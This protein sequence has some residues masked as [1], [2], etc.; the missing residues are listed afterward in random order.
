VS[1]EQPI[2]HQHRVLS[3]NEECSCIFSVCC[4]VTRWKDYA[5]IR[6]AF[7]LQGFDTSNSEFLVCDNSSG[8][9]F[10]AYE[11][12]RKFMKEARGRYTLIVH[13][14]AYPLE[15]SSKLIRQL[16]ELEKVDP[17]WGVVG[18]AGVNRR[19][20]LRLVGALQMPGGAEISLDTP[21]AKVDAVD[22][23]VL[24]VRNG[25]GV[26]VSSDLRGFHLYGLD[27]CSVAARLGMSSYVIDYRWYH[28]S[29]GTI[30][31]DFFIT[32][33]ALQRKLK[34]YF[35]ITDSPTTCSYLSWS[36][37][38]CRGALADARSFCQVALG[39][40]HKEAR[41]CTLKEGLRNPLFLPALLGLI[42]FY[43]PR[44]IFRRIRRAFKARQ[45]SKHNS[46]A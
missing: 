10:D 29:Y 6:S 20:W 12:I 31:N 15:H 34:A 25:S 8:N 17:L 32:R 38:P 9:N 13:Q 40:R 28:G 19:M 22:E 33:S 43:G 27:I 36:R 1:R 21:F 30:G 16:V 5:A 4:L 14:D 11:A 3:N 2:E 42:L 7:E 24:I 39:K 44:A 37:N 41:R 46:H 23:N 35:S 26:T 45:V 18:N